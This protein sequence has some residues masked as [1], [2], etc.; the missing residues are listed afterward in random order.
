VRKH[1][2]K[3][4][5]IAPAAAGLALTLALSGCGGSGSSPQPVTAVN[6]Q[7]GKLELAV[8]TANIFGDLGG[9]A[10]GSATGLNVVS[11]F[12]QVQGQQTVGASATLVNTPSLSGPMTLPAPLVNADSY[13]ATI[14]SGTTN[15]ET[16][17]SA[18]TATAQPPAGTYP[19]NPSTFGVSNGVYAAGIEPFNSTVVGGPGELP[20]G[21]PVSYV[22]NPVPA[23]DPVN[24]GDFSTTPASAPV[25]VFND[26]NAFVPFGGPPAFDL[27]KTGRGTRDGLGEPSTE[28]GIEEGLDVFQGVVPR[29]GTYSLNVVI[30]TLSSNLA[31]STTAALHSTTLLP[32]IIP[33]AAV[34]TDGN[35]G[36]S[37]IPVVVPAGVTEAFVQITDFGPTVTNALSCNGSSTSTPAYYTIRVT[38][39]STVALAPLIGP[40]GVPSATNPSLCT[41]TQNTNFSNANGSGLTGNSDGDAF[42]VQVVGFDYPAY[43][44]TPIKELGNPAPVLTGSSGQSDITISSATQ[45]TQAAGTTGPQ[46]LPALRRGMHLRRTGIHVRR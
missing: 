23:Y 33:P 43:A 41:S 37:S 39:S 46:P 30:P 42:S 2:I 13:G 14:L 44:S 16:A 31:V 7:Q 36:L 12:R 9:A 11:S 25:F 17:S 1:T 38:A 26:P 22:P 29:V 21:E 4:T 8:G 18:I 27:N 32:A 19:V 35:G 28:L 10:N 40:V 24:A 6:P 20:A 3:I 45:F 34:T 5:R 15:A